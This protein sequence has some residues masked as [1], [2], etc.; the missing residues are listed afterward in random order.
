MSSQTVSITLPEPLYQR[1]CETAKA[2][3]RSVQDVLT[4][5]IA[6][7][8]PPLEAD[9]PADLRADLGSLALSSPQELQ[10]I[11]HRPLD[12]KSQA[13]LEAL[14]EQQKKQSLSEA[15]RSELDECIQKAQHLMLRRAE[16]RR[17]LVLRGYE[18]F[19]KHASRS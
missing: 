4:E 11:A 12:A 15:E 2:L 8:L 5:S 14:A 10:E 13:R 9:L 16:A 1:V 18:L 6:L 19:P 17:L 3:T 7:S